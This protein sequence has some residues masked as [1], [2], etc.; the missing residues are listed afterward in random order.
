MTGRLIPWLAV[1]IAMSAGLPAVQSIRSDAADSLEQAEL[2]VD[3][4]LRGYF[5]AEIRKYA[6]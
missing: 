3:R 5:A 1:L 2:E 4:S 6:F